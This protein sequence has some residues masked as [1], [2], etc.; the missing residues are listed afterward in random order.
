MS[1]LWKYLLTVATCFTLSQ[2]AFADTQDTKV[3]IIKAEP[4]VVR[5]GDSSNVVIKMYRFDSSG[6]PVIPIGTD[7]KSVV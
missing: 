5:M 4:R 7:R 2:P 6:K 1:H 3:V